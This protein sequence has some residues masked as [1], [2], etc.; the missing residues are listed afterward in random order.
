MKVGDSALSDDIGS[1]T[2]LLIPLLSFL[3]RDTVDALAQNSVEGRLTAKIFELKT[4]VI[5]FET[6]L[7]AS[8]CP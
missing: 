3:G 2:T 8:F 6:F 7:T 5:A 4:E 1:G